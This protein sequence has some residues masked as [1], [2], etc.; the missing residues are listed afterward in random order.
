MK[1]TFSIIVGA[2]IFT[3]YLLATNQSPAD[4]VGIHGGSRFQ[5][6]ANLWNQQP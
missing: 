4:A 2:L 1:Y 6:A 5:Q 3:L